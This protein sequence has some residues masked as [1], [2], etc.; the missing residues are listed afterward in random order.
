MSY[1]FLYIVINL[2]DKHNTDGVGKNKIRTLTY[3]FIYDP[4]TTTCLESICQS[5]DQFESHLKY[6]NENNYFSLRMIDLDLYMDGK[7]NC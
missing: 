6:I 3:H 1:Y 2:Y 7:I 5:F 4:N